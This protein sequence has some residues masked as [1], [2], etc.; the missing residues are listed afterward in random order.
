MRV[1]VNWNS[2]APPEIT[3]TRQG[4]IRGLIVPRAASAPGFPTVTTNLLRT[5]SLGLTVEGVTLQQA[6]RPF[7]EVS[8]EKVSPQGSA[9]GIYRIRAGSP[10]PGCKADQLEA[11]VD[12]EKG[13]LIRRLDIIENV[14]FVGKRRVLREV[15]SFRDCGDGIFFPEL[16]EQ[17]IWIP[18]KAK[19]S[20]SFVT[21]QVTTLD[22]NQPISPERFTLPFPKD[23]LVGVHQQDGSYELQLWG[24]DDSPIETI[25]DMKQLGFKAQTM[26]W[27]YAPVLVLLTGVLGLAVYWFLTIRG[28]RPRR[29]E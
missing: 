23:L 22:V 27:F 2:D 9:V 13:F 28:R 15:K 7:K 1:L 24:P 4:P 6:L 29:G 18:G 17:T 20:T 5:V 11:E 19:A 14:D 26:S 25:T 3:P 21:T 12:P 10:Q 8:I 16:V